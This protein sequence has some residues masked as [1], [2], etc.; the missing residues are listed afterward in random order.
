MADVAVHDAEQEGE[1][2]DGEQTGVGLL[3]A[4]HSIRVHDAL[5]AFSELVELEVGGWVVRDANGIGRVGLDG[6]RWVARSL[7][8][9]PA[10]L[11]DEMQV[12][13]WYPALEGR[14]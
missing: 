1:G 3:I 7:Y 4:R 11:L 10:G 2:D 9:R 8:S 12:G 14:S 6:G 5:E 13:G